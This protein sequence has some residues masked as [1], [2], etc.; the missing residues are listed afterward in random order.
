MNVNIV[1]PTRTHT[2][3]ST[4]LIETQRYEKLPGSHV[5]IAIP[6][7]IHLRNI[8]ACQQQHECISKQKQ[9]ARLMPVSISN[10]LIF[11]ISV[12]IAGLA[13]LYFH[14]SREHVRVSTISKNPSARKTTTH[15]FLLIVSKAVDAGEVRTEWQLFR[16]RVAAKLIKHKKSKCRDFHFVP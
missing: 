7:H 8:N 3:Y 12:F 1:P 16:Q 13:G 2:E 6:H 9:N 15:F 5:A 11:M 14:R 4:F 10:G